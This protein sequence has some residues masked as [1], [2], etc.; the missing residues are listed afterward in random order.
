[1]CQDTESCQAK[2]SH[3]WARLLGRHPKLSRQTP[4]AHAPGCVVRSAV[5]VRSVVLSQ[6]GTHAARSQKKFT[7]RLINKSEIS[8]ESHATDSKFKRDPLKAERDPV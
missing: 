5:V 1:V 8:K 6:A 7:P 3:S 2:I 4:G